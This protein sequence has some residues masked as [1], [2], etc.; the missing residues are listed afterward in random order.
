MGLIKVAQMLGDVVAGNAQLRVLNPLVGEGLRDVSSR[1]ALPLQSAA[2]SSSSGGVSSFGYSGTIVHI[3]LQHALIESR[4]SSV[5]PLFTL[6]RRAFAWHVMAHPSSWYEPVIEF[7][8]DSLRCF[9][10]RLV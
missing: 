5:S 9:Y 10:T 4:L 2:M 6:K 3:L 1:F 7:I 8:S